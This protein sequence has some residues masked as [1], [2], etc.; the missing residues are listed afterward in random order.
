MT[1][2]GQRNEPV[3]NWQQELS[4]IADDPGCGKRNGLAP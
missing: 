4:R 2:C 3:G 1:I